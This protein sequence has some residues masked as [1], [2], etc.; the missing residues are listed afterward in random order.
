MLKDAGLPFTKDAAQAKL[1]A[2]EAATFCAHQAIQVGSCVYDIFFCDVKDGK[3]SV[4][5]IHICLKSELSCTT[6]DWQS[7]FVVF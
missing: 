7:S 2:S 3:F 4:V 5:F 1:F 6:V